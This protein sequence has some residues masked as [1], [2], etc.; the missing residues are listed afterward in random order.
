SPG[1]GRAVL[2]TPLTR[3][4]RSR[5]YRAALAVAGLSA[6]ALTLSGLPAGAAP[7]KARPHGFDTLAS[8][9]HGGGTRSGK[10]SRLTAGTGGGGAWEP[11][12]EAPSAPSPGDLQ[13]DAKGRLWFAAGEANT[14]ADSYVGSGVY[15]LADPR[16]GQFQPGGRVGGTE[17]DG[18]T[19]KHLR[20]A[21]GT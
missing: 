11:I 12:S 21:G 15:V 8:I 1:R 20:F 10:V 7:A 9:A 4:F 2:P 17:L 3:T 5:K 13:L 18:T 14:N 19:I 6:L 16:H